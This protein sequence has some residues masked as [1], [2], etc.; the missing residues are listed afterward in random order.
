[1]ISSSR[2]GNGE[3]ALRDVICCF[4]EPWRLKIGARRNSRWAIL[5]VVVCVSCLKS[6]LRCVCLL[7]GVG[8]LPFCSV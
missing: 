3:V 8:S 6:V 5:M 1:M 2:P 4:S 7:S